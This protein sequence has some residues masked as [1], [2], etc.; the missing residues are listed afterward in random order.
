MRVDKSV[1]LHLERRV[2]SWIHHRKHVTR[3]CFSETPAGL[4]TKC[5]K[6][7]ATVGSAAESSGSPCGLL[8]SSCASPRQRLGLLPFAARVQ[9]ERLSGTRVRNVGPVGARVAAKG[10][11]CSGEAVHGARQTPGKSN[12]VCRERGRCQKTSGVR[13]RPRPTSGSDLSPRVHGVVSVDAVPVWRSGT[14]LR[15]ASSH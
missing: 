3:S 6:M 15:P 11:A 9:Q 12:D 2:L 1:W 8:G 10:A 5:H 7:P 14:S 4:G 13:A